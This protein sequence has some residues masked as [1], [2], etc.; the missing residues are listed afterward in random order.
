MPRVT[1]ATK[2]R[3][4]KKVYRCR[5]CG[6]EIQP[7]QKYYKY[8]FRYGGTYY[9]CSS[10]FPKGSEL[11]QSKMSTV[12]AAIEDAEARLAQ[13]LSFDGDI[14]DFDADQYTEAAREIVAE[15]CTA[16]EEVRDEYQAGLDEWEHG[17]SQIEERVD[18]MTAFVDALEGFDPSAT[19]EEPDKDDYSSDEV[20]EDAKKARAEELAAEDDEV[21]DDLGETEQEYYLSMAEDA[22]KEENAFDQEGY[23]DAVRDAIDNYLSEL[24]G[25]VEDVFAESPA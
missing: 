14:G 11:T 7:G 9:H 6:T 17:N 16:A 20:D 19:Y 10:H 12:L 23:E 3:G 18:E 4:G 2:N 13:E 24:R 8:S 22:L 1:T 5:R 21:F 25:E 15:V